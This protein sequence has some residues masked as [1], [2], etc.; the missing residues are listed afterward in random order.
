MPFVAVQQP[1]A[2]V[3]DTAEAGVQIT[4]NTIKK[5]TVTPKKILNHLVSFDT[6]DTKYSL[7]HILY[8]ASGIPLVAGKN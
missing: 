6:S 5:R 4:Y 7:V 3:H 8:P 2:L 1:P